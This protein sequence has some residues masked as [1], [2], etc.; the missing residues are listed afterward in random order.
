MLHLMPFFYFGSLLGGLLIGT[1][2]GRWLGG[3]VADLRYSQTPG[4]APSPQLHKGCVAAGA[5]LGCI[6]GAAVGMGLTMVVERQV[7]AMWLMP[8]IFFSP[9][10]L[11]LVLGGFAGQTVARR[12]AAQRTASDLARNQGERGAAS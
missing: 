8:I 9:P 5:L 2:A 3:L 7:Q 6:I 10:V 11:F 1:L 12:R 4:T